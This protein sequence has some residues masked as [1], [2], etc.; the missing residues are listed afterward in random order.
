MARGKDI[1]MRQLRY[2]VAAADAGQFSQAALKVH[3]SQS[4]ITA[5]VL[6]LEETLGAS[7]FERLPYGVALTA[8]GHK[9]A[10]HARHILDTLQDALS[11]PLLLGHSMQGVVR[12]GASYT[13]LGYFLPALLARFKRS[14]PQV[15]IDLIDMD[16][17]SIE[18]AVADGCLDLGL[19]ITSNSQDL[20]R[21]E[22]HVLIR[23]RRQ[24]WLASQHP[25]MTASSVTLEDVAGH[26]YILATVDEGDVSTNRY[27]EAQGLAPQVAFRTS[28]M[29]ALRGL[30]AHGFG[31]AILSDMLYRAW[32]LEGKKIEA[33][34]L[35]D[36]IPPM[37]LGLVWRPD[38]DLPEPAQAF[39]Q[40]LIMACAS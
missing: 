3:V 36:A 40:F 10:L 12:V 28:S 30:V 21:F 33:R 37:E 7:L 5:A 6:Q 8:E 38:A 11:E 26:A 22:H 2:F 16:R 29:E 31:V 20:S 19:V 1:S 25:L 35:A 4:A 23:S 39:R 24:L 27:W 13:V 15:E 32:S 14:Y 18:A 9:F 34:P 17:S